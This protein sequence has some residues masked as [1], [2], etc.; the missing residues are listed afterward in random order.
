MSLFSTCRQT[1]YKVKELFHFYIRVISVI[2]LYFLPICSYIY[3]HYLILQLAYFSSFFT[4]FS[5]THNIARFCRYSHDRSI[6]WLSQLGENFSNKS[7]F[8]VYLYSYWLLFLQV[9]YLLLQI[10]KMHI[11]FSCS[12]LWASLVARSVKN[13]PPMQETQV[14]FL[15]QE[16]SLEKEIAT[17][18]G[19]LVWRIPWTEEPSGLQSMGLQ[20]LDTTEQFH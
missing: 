4:T 10:M 6:I 12:T 3:N 5:I 14:H 18:S 2:T 11:L 9:G 20:E 8:G 19:I 7:N 1:P 15:G 17:H 13:L 16:D